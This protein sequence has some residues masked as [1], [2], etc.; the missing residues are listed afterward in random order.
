MCGAGCACVVRGLLEGMCA[1]RAWEREVSSA[2]SE[3]GWICDGLCMM[4]KA[5]LGGRQKVEGAG[6]GRRT[7]WRGASGVVQMM[8]D[9]SAGEKCTLGE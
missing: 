9:R 5:G 1:M 8:R 7:G 3:G 4:G 6:S 2:G